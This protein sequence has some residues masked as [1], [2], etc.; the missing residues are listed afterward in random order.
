MAG[1]TEVES[2]AVA[3]WVEVAA[4]AAAGWAAAEGW[5]AALAEAV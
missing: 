2:W 4:M 5:V 1:M 3:D